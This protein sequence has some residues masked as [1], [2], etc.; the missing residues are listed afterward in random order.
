MLN[1]CPLAYTD[2][3]G[4]CAQYGNCTPSQAAQRIEV[5]E[6]HLLELKQMVELLLEKSHKGT[7][8]AK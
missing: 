6:S 5:L 8:T 7:L 3:C 1:G 2:P 4:E